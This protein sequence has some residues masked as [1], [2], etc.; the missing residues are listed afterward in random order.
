VGVPRTPSE[1]DSSLSYKEV[2]YGLVGSNPTA[3][4]MVLE[5][6]T[7]A[8]TGCDPVASGFDSRPSPHLAEQA[9][10]DP[11]NPVEELVEERPVDL[12]IR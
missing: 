6:N 5:G 7:G 11:A 4:T 9:T 3:Y 2:G 12:C 8:P 1:L 10:P